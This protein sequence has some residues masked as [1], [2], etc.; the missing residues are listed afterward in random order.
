MS[1]LG[2]I[3]VLGAIGAVVYFKFYKQE[4]I[5]GTSIITETARSTMKDANADYVD[6]KLQDQ[7]EYMDR[8]ATVLQ[9]DPS[10]RAIT[11]KQGQ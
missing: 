1:N 11:K 7:R 2:K 4:D 10:M 3:V 5:P 6:H 9:D 8:N